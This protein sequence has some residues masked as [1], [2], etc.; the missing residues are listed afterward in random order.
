MASS[1][2]AMVTVGQVSHI[3][4]SGEIWIRIRCGPLGIIGVKLKISATSVTLCILI[5]Y[6]SEGIE[7]H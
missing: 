6:L 7:L 2:G 1:R 5:N 3:T 4:Q